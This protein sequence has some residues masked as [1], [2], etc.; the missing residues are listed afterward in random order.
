VGFRASSR[1]AWRSACELALACAVISACGGGAGLSARDVAFVDHGATQQSG[2]DGAARIA[3][4]TDP[5]QS[6]L[7]ALASGAAA[8]RLYLGVFAGTQR[9]GGYAIHVDRVERRGDALVVRATFTSPPPD[10]ITI[11]VLTSPAQLISVE[12]GSVSGAREA[13]LLDQS[14]V[15]RARAPVPQSRS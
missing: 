7:G 9:T 13:V 15:E 3:A 1:T 8:G 14:G 5:A 10:A 12:Q 2:H 11:Q 4:A 6:G